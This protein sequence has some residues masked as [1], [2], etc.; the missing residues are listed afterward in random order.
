M[1]RFWYT[2]TIALIFIFPTL[3][4]AQKNERQ[5]IKPKIIIPG[6]SVTQPKSVRMPSFIPRPDIDYKIQRLAVDESIDYK[7]IDLAPRRDSKIVKKQNMPKIRP[8]LF[9]YPGI[10]K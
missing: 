7:I 4:Y 1:K 10:L 8:P 3:L 6:P 2:V 5:E 9:K